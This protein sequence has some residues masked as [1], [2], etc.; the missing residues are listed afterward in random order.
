M[1]YRCRYCILNIYYTALHAL[2]SGCE[3]MAGFF[4]KDATDLNFIW[5]KI[6]G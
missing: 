4:L 6:T 1:I 5:K 2:E 3:C